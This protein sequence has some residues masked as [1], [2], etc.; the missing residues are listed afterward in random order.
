M[1]QRDPDN[2]IWRVVCYA[3]DGATEE[4]IAFE[5]MDSE[6]IRQ[7]LFSRAGEP[8]ARLDPQTS[9]IDGATPHAVWAAG[10]DVRHVAVLW[11]TAQLAQLDRQLSEL[12]RQIQNADSRRS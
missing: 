7:L 2:L 8:A 11:T 1:E 5:Q 3:A 10:T 9:S 6:A 12:I 4:R